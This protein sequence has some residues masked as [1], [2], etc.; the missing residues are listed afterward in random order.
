MAEYVSRDLL[1]RYTSL[2]SGQTE[3]QQRNRDVAAARRG[4]VDA[5]MP[6]VFPKNWPRPVVAKLHDHA[7]TAGAACLAL[8]MFSVDPPIDL[9]AL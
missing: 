9:D 6:G 5:I 3:R 4:D 1:G 7:G 8:D 2:I